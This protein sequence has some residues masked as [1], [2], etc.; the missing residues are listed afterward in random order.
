MGVP[1][2]PDYTANVPAIAKPSALK[3]DRG[4]ERNR[5][6]T[7]KETAM[8]PRRR[9]RLF[10]AFVLAF[11]AC[12]PTAAH[13]ATRDWNQTFTVGARPVVHVRSGDARVHVFPGAPGTVRVVVHWESR[14][15]GFTSAAREPQVRLEKTGDGVEIEVREPAEFA[16]F[17]GISERTTID[18]AVPSECVLGVHTGDGSIDLGSSLRGV[19][20]LATGDGRVSLRDIHG[21]VRVTSGY[22]AIDASDIDGSLVAHAGDGRIRVDGRFDVLDVRSGDGHVVVTARAGSR[23][24]SDWSVETRDAGLEIAIPRNLAADLDARTGD[25]RI[26]FDLPVTVNGRLNP[27]VIRGHLNGGGPTLRL[28]TGDGSLTLGVS[29]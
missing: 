18:V 25:G 2:Q 27:H 5:V 4:R 21:D 24:A 19:F 20:D 16:V 26:H 22:G 23:M 11:A 9:F 3:P 1:E 14:H 15:W 29:N 28:R 8:P 13:A 17:G 10:A 7:W 6:M 12:R